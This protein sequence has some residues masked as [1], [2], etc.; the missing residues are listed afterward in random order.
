MRTSLLLEVSN[1]AYLAKINQMSL[2]VVKG[3]NYPKLISDLQCINDCKYD[4]KSFEYLKN[5]LIQDINHIKIV[6]NMMDEH[7]LPELNYLCSIYTEFYEQLESFTMEDIEYVCKG[8][9]SPYIAYMLMY[10]HRLNRMCNVS[11]PND[12]DIQSIFK[13]ILEKC[14]NDDIKTLKQMYHEFQTIEDK[15]LIAL[16]FIKNVNMNAAQFKDTVNKFNNPKFN[17]LVNF[18]TSFIIIDM[19]ELN[20]IKE[21][22]YS[23]VLSLLTKIYLLKFKPLINSLDNTNELGLVMQ[24]FLQSAIKCKF[25]VKLLNGFYKYIDKNYIE[26]VTSGEINTNQRYSSFLNIAYGNRFASLSSKLPCNSDVM[27]LFNYALEAKKLA[28]LKVLEENIELISNVDSSKVIFTPI[29]KELINFNE[30]N[31]KDF[32]EMCQTRFNSDV[33]L[34]KRHITPKELLA[35]SKC[36]NSSIIKIY[37]KLTSKVDFNLITLQQLIKINHDFSKCNDEELERVAARLSIQMLS[38][39]QNSFSFPVSYHTLLDSLTLDESYNDLMSQTKNE[40]ELIFIYRNRDINNETSLDLNCSLKENLA[41]YMSKD[42]DCINLFKLLN[43]SDDFKEANQESIQIFCTNG[44][45]SIVMDYYNDSRSFQKEAILK[46]TKAEMANDFTR[47]KF[48]DLEKEVEMTLSHIEKRDWVQNC[49]IKAN[50]LEVI[51]SYSFIDTMM[52]GAKPGHTCMNYKDG[53]YNQC[54]LANFDSNKKVLYAYKDGEIVG[55]AIIR[56]TKSFLKGENKNEDKGKVSFLD[57]ETT[58]GT[59]SDS[60][61]KEKLTIFLERPYFS[62]INSQVIKTLE[63]MFCSL[64][65]EKAIGLNARFVISDYFSIKPDLKPMF[66]EVF[67]SHSKNGVQYMDSFNGERSSSD[68][69]QYVDCSGYTM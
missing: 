4:L 25:D 13:C 64:V 66:C 31:S 3:G 33:V 17:A 27:T 51:E 68:E 30:I 45:A 22:E 39:W 37:D 5:Y 53:I 46:I 8:I 61:S 65:M 47:F 48:Y 19:D 69:G 20:V 63:K 32:I 44:Y 36:Y 18:I 6:E 12:Y 62:G 42:K 67:I 24:F 55:R 21:E 38:K 10:M 34:V 52:I 59:N 54:L 57:V 35:L 1:V 15:N 56:F 43:L 29:T 23:N 7:L 11:F 41:S 26:Y 50:T 28:F 14:G 2:E 9:K 16:N 60:L 49:S 40:N 58:S